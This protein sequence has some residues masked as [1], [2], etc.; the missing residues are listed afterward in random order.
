MLA[1][2]VAFLLAD[3]Q[4]T[5][6]WLVLPIT[7]AQPIG[8]PLETE[9]DDTLQQVRVGGA[10]VV[11]LFRKILLLG[12]FRVRIGFQHVD[13]SVRVESE[14]NTGVTAEI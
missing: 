8:S 1:P 9:V 7:L 13:L 4:T 6:A 12:N 2:F 14:I 11:S 5:G 10:R 3:C